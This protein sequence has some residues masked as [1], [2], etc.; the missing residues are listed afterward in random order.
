MGAIPRILVETMNEKIVHDALGEVGVID[1][2]PTY[3]I[4][5]RY[6]YPDDVVR[7][8]EHYPV[9]LQAD[10]VEEALVGAHDYWRSLPQVLRLIGSEECSNCLNA[11]ARLE[12]AGPEVFLIWTKMFERL[13]KPMG[14]DFDLAQVTYD[15]LYR[16]EFK[17]QLAWVDDVN[18]M[19]PAM[20]KDIFVRIRRRF[21]EGAGLV[22][23]RDLYEYV[24]LPEHDVMGLCNAVR[25]NN[26]GNP[27]VIHVRSLLY[28]DWEGNI[29]F[30]LTRQIILANGGGAP[31][32]W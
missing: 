20:F 27:Q 19:T 3:V 4:G 25:N 7:Q 1:H 16:K 10:I 26:G 17:S 2:F 14:F 18:Y 32:D 30:R 28:N 29:A 23:K 8:I 31:I 9:S 5:G 22:G 24:M 15:S 11:F 6:K 12:L 13:F 21:V